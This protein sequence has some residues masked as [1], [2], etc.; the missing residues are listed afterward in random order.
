M[1]SFLKKPMNLAKERILKSKN[2]YIASHV[3][4]DGDNLGSM[5]A[6]GLALK[7]INENVYLVQTDPVPS[8]FMFLPGAEDIKEVTDFDNI[9]L[10]ITLDSSDIERLG[11]NK[12]IID[13]A[14]FVINIDHHIS[15]TNYGDINIVD[16]KSGSTAELIFYLIKVLD[17][18]IHKDIGTCIYTGISTDTG[19]FMYDNTRPE[20]H[21]IAAELL[22]IGIDKKNIILN[23]YQNNSLEKTNLF[24]KT[25]ENLEMFA[26]NKIAVVSVTRDILKN[27]GAK[28]EDTDG[29]ISFIRDIQPVEVAILLKE[30][31]SEEIKVS[32]RSKKYVNVAEV[33][34]K[35][36][37]GGH[38]RAA[39]C[40]VYDSLEFAK[41]ALIN[42]LKKVL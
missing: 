25:I 8:D 14:N 36:E 35:F 39:G 29:I 6:L 26:E 22:N 31:Q 30:L 33:C 11:Q 40:T 24:I 17:I 23:V 9:D 10:F 13:K 42:E 18:K 5:L 15:N 2:I 34:S 37:G 21:L 7:S 1:N 12:K 27:T 41:T 32:M 28:M 38:I 19:S 4:P 16:S 20:T 3:R